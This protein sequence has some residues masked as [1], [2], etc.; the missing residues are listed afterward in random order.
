MLCLL[1][2]SFLNLERYEEK[3]VFFII[4]STDKHECKNWISSGERVCTDATKILE[5][6]CLTMLAFHKM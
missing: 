5:G 2:F 1:L 3:A 6:G 4:L